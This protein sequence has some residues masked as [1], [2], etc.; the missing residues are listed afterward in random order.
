MRLFL[1]PQ[2]EEGGGDGGQHVVFMT[3]VEDTPL[4]IPP[5]VV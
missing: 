1:F 5:M 2:C 3:A 4:K